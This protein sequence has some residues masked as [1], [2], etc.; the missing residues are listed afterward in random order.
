MLVSYG[1]YRLVPGVLCPRC[2]PKVLAHGSPTATSTALRSGS[3]YGGG[4]YG[5]RSGSAAIRIRNEITCFLQVVCEPVTSTDA[6]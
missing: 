1:Q 5:V 3:A 6:D 2:A 4:S